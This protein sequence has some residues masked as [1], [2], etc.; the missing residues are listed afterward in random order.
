M[1]RHTKLAIFLTPFL[2]IGGYVASDYY[3]EYQANQPKV[4]P[5]QVEDDCDIMKKQCI[6]SSGEF[7]LSIYQERNITV[8]NSTFPLDKATL[9]VANNEQSNQPY[10]LGMKESAYYWKAET[11]LAD[12]LSAVGSSKTLRIVAQIK[13]SSYISEFTSTTL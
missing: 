10:P 2:M 4:I 7:K 12:H 6:L 1:N 3:A 8:V 13:G 5:L 9:L 11:P